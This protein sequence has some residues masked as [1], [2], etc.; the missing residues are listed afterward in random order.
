[1]RK[2]LNRLKGGTVAGETATLLG[3]N[4]VA[5]AISMLAYLIL[6][7]IYSPEDYALFNIFYSYIEVLI[8]VSTCKYELAIVVARD[9]D[10]AAA[11]ARFALRMN[12]LVSLALLAVASLLY[13]THSLPGDYAELGAVALLV[14]PM[15]W[16][17]GSSRI[18]SGLYNR[19]R[20]YR[21]MAASSITNASAGSALKII[22]GALGMHSTGL[23]LGT[24]LGQATANGIYRLRMRSL[25][26]PHTSRLQRLNAARQHRN[27]PLYVA[28]KDFLNS[29]SANL[30]FLW[31]AFH[32]DRAEVGLFGLALTFTFRPVNLL[33]GAFESV[34]YA[35]TAERVRQ[36][37]SIGRTVGRFLLAVNAISLP[38]AVAAWFWAEPI[39]VF[40][41]GD[42][43]H[44][45]GQ[46]VQAL[47][48]WMFILMS[49][50]SLM[51]IPN[52]FSTQRMEFGFY[53]VTFALRAA[54]LA[55]GIHLGNFLT[56]IRLY[57]AASAAMALAI[58]TW[59]L[60][61]VLRYE[62]SLTRKGR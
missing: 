55:T 32:F 16:L 17:A 56:A 26:L 15:V 4:I 1:M 29:L 40:F 7:R 23:P 49:S 54:A 59:Y 20:R 24:L 33:N 61:Q 27:F 13:L 62:R 58:L 53:L 12:T 2:V 48:P 25:Q 57:A 34:L 9:G 44:G 45:C 47:I 50:A 35:H 60:W 39:F 52:L 46:Y 8:I 43:W 37:E 21:T 6:T 30:P 22:F 38:I 28:S 10:E 3:G 14:P 11:V 51:F 19:V 31:L 5:Q 18:Y 42:Q 36:R 41:F